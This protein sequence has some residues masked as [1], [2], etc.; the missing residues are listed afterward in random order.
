LLIQAESGEIVLVNATHEGH[1]ELAKLEALNGRTWNY[2]ALS[3]DILVVRNDH[4]A[5]AYQ[6]PLKHDQS[7]LASSSK[8]ASLAQN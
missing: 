6:L 1:Q 7:P 4:E 8:R 5:A 2:P 3:G